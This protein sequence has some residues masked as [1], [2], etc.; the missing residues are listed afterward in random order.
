MLFDDYT[1][2]M[3]RGAKNGIDFFVNKFENEIKYHGL[4]NGLYIIKKS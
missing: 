3:Y 2:E 1:S 4:K